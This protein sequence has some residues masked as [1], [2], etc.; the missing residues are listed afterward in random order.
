MPTNS[1]IGDIL[2]MNKQNLIEYL[3]PLAPQGFCVAFSGGVDSAVLL[4]ACCSLTQNV[5]AVTV[6]TPLH[7]KTESA[8]AADLAAVIGCKHTVIKITS[9]P[10][11]VAENTPERCYLC[12]NDIFCRIKAYAAENDLENVLDG[13]NLDDLSQYRPGLRALAELGI[14]SPLRECELTKQQV[15]EIATEFSL[16]VARKPS[17][18]CLATRFPYYDKLITEQ[19]AKVGTIEAFMHNLGFAIVRARVHNNIL[20]LELPT[21]RLAEA[22]NK[23]CEIADFC[24]NLGFAYTTLDLEGFRS[25]SMDILP[26]QKS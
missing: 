14:I 24:K 13:T 22:V 12:K 5:H 17:T 11:T 19:L 6:Q 3:R 18:P 16:S 25:G 1:R 9:I 8:E 26:E 4:A 7:Q 21:D 10:D 15:R 20:R 23:Y 2:I